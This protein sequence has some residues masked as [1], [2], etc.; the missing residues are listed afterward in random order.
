MNAKRVKRYRTPAY[1]TRLEVLSRPELLQRNLPPGWQVVP[2]MAG[3]VALFLALNSVLLAADSKPGGAVAVVAPIFDHGEGRGSTGCIVVAPPV[4]L[5]EEE[6]WQ[7]IREVLGEKGVELTERKRVLHGVSLPLAEQMEDSHGEISV[8]ARRARQTRGVSDADPEAKEPFK[9][10]AA[11]SKKRIAVEF[12]S[13]ADFM[14]VCGP[15]WSRPNGSHC[16]SSVN[17]YRLKDLAGFVAEQVRKEAQEKVYCGVFYDPIGLRQ[18]EERSK[19]TKDGEDYW[20]N[21]P[22]RGKAESQRL[23]RLQVRDFVKWL[24]G[25]GAI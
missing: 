24:Q 17:T 19:G 2:E 12:V 4:F 10:D 7:V 8:Q 1:P 9:V 11:D 23:L 3:T 14:R 15:G 18:R 16:I 6:A 20:Q 21:R 5:S 22:V 13:S 25:Q